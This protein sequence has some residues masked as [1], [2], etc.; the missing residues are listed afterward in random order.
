MFVL[1]ALWVLAAIAGLLAAGCGGG[2]PCQVEGENCSM[3]YREANGI[4]YGC[5]EGL[6]CSENAQA[7]LVCR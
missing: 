6:S 4:D 2:D 5:C 7:D 1:R 3:A